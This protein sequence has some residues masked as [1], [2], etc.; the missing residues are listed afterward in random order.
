MVPPAPAIGGRVFRAGGGRG[1]HSA[2]GNGS[3]VIGPAPSLGSGVI[4]ARGNGSTLGGGGTQVVGPAPSLEGTGRLGG[5]GGKSDFGTING[6]AVAPAPG[7]GEMAVHGGGGHGRGF[8]SL[9]GDGTQVVAPAPTLASSGVGTG[10]G[11]NGGTG[12]ANLGSQVL[13]PGLGGGQGTGPG[14]VAGA[15]SGG[16]GS[17]GS[18]AGPGGNGSGEGSSGSGTRTMAGL[19]GG[20][21]IGGGSGQ[22]STPIISSAVPKHTVPDLPAG[23]TEVVPLRVVQLALALPMSSFFSNYEAFVAERS[24]NRNT[25]QLI[26]LVYIFLPYERR[27]TEIG[28]NTSKTF[29]LRVTRDP[30]CDESLISMTWPEGEAPGKPAES[31]KEKLPCYRTTADDYRKAW[32]KSR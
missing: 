3:E 17:N 9:T 1:G 22:A 13:P 4:L 14:G 21:A 28:V 18:A 19:T 24:V 7:V 27:L 15:G 12:F 29:H 16:N 23:K 26:K 30:S 2:R 25:S 8:G 5:G 31:D 10:T 6:G 32:E 20:T 11:G